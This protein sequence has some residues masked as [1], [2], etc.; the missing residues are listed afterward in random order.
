MAA[1]VAGESSAQA[2]PSAWSDDRRGVRQQRSEPVGRHVAAGQGAIGPNLTDAYW[3][4][5]G[6]VKDIFKTIKY[7]VIEK[8]MTPWQDQLKPNEMQAV[9]SY[10]LSLQGTNPEG[11]KEPQGEL[12]EP[13]SAAPA[14]T[15]TSIS[16][17]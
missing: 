7:G 11:A 8:G 3:I 10:I 14:D 17:N 9:S 4:H 2:P 5:G 1:A 12:Y 6:D 16:M 15:T 13:G